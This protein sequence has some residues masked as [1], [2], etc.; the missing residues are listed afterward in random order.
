MRYLHLI[1]SV[2]F[3][4]WRFTSFHLDRIVI[5]IFPCLINR[6]VIEIMVV[7][8][9]I[10]ISQAGRLDAGVWSGECSPPWCV[11]Y[12]LWPL[13]EVQFG[14]SPVPLLSITASPAPCSVFLSAVPSKL[15]L[16]TE[17]CTPPHTQNRNSVTIDKVL[18]K[19]SLL[20]WLTFPFETSE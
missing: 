11:N 16:S 20:R 2:I 8:I 3:F 5:F 9:Y 4:K 13:L 15:A 6:C 7:F 19:S 18:I 14:I 12:S 17:I 10:G 1:Y